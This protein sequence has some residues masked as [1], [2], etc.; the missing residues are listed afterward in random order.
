MPN[1]KQEEKLKELMEIIKEHGS[2][3]NVCGDC[4]KHLKFCDEIKHDYRA[5]DFIKLPFTS[6]EGII[7]N[8]WVEIMKISPD[9]PNAKSYI[10]G[11]LAS[12]PIYATHLEEGVGIIL[13]KEHVDQIKDVFYNQKNARKKGKKEKRD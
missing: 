2:V 5:G 11:R 9:I 12:K 1:K 13:N 4:Q 3:V 10:L 7:E 6:K 8:M